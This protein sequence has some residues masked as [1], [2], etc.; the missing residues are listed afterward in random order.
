MMIMNM[1]MIM[2]MT[3]CSTRSAGLA[4]ST[5]D[6]QNGIHHQNYY[7]HDDYADHDD[8]YDHDDYDN[9][10]DDHQLF[11]EISRPCKLNQ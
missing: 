11:N 9:H 7:D 2:M 10:D 5:K 4:S 6:N 1:I 8:Y 3:S